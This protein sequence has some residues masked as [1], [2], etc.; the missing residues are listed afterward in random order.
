MK[1]QIRNNVFETNSSSTHSI[2]VVSFNKDMLD[3]PKSITFEFGEYG[4][5]YEMYNNTSEKAAYLWT[6]IT[7]LIEEKTKL[8]VINKINYYKSQIITIL[9]SVGLTDISFIEP[10]INRI[11]KGD[12]E[13]WTTYPEDATGYNGGYIDHVRDL[14]GWPEEMFA[15]P[16]LLLSYLF[17][18]CSGIATGCDSGEQELESIPND[19]RKLAID[20]VKGN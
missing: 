1:L 3:I 14:Q 9:N 10:T 4:W 5:E 15:N 2:T 7:T 13:T 16:E 8:E 17:D 20:F 19:G 18:S 11:G 12:R 6:A